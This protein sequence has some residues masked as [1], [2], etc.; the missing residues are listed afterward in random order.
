MDG[1]QIHRKGWYNPYG[2]EVAVTATVPHLVR[3]GAG[4]GKTNLRIRSDER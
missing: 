4:V 2:M 3:R 1:R